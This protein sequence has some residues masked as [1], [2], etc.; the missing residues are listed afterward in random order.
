MEYVKINSLWKRN[1]WYFDQDKKNSPDYQLGRQSFIIGDYAEPE[2]GN[3]KNWSVEEKVDGTNIRITFNSH[4]PI[5][6]GGLKFEG[7]TADAQIPCHLLNYLQMHFTHDRLSKVFDFP[8]YIILF[9]E[10]YGPK[11]QKGGGNY[12]NSPGFI[13]FDVVIAQ[14]W[15]QRPDVKDIAD[16]LEIPM[17]PQLG[18]MNEFEIVE[19]VKSKPLS[20]CSHTPQVME[21]VICRSE[22]LVLFRK[23]TPIMWKLKCKEFNS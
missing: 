19:L 22:P 21:G 12:R 5:E 2:F 7:R 16:K 6:L 18:I 10:G 8:G 3:I 1:G 23:G 13:L 9:G 11:I 17:V 15:L 14:W 20:I 4:L